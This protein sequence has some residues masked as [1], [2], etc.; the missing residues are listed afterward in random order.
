MKSAIL[1]DIDGTLVDS[2][3]LHILAW[4]EAFRDAGFVFS[5][6]ELHRHIGKGGDTYV[7]SLLPNAPEKQQAEIAEGHGR[8]YKAKYIEQVRPF[9][10]ARELLLRTRDSGRKVVLASSA[11]QEELD[12][13]L[14]LLDARSIVAATT[15]KDDVEHSKPCPDI[16]RTAAQKAQAAPDAALVVGDT[17]FD[18]EAASRSGIAS[19]AVRSGKFS[20]E[21]LRGSLAI[22]DDVAALLSGFDRS[23]LAA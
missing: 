9:P 20:D 11:S 17:P 19:V 8:V 3:E 5:R 7:P 15:S 6:D 13:Y 14:E 4:D 16:F 23:P 21:H 10:G 18:I 12:H 1:F 22:Y 2:N